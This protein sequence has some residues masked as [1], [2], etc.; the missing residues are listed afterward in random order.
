MALEA[1]WID[2]YDGFYARVDRELSGV[3]TS[4]SSRG[5]L[6]QMPRELAHDQLVRRRLRRPVNEPRQSRDEVADGCDD[7]TRAGE[8]AKLEPAI[9]N[10]RIARQRASRSS[11]RF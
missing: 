2:G 11:A 1:R 9:P 10:I 3:A 7:L 6:R 5:E 4:P 8:H